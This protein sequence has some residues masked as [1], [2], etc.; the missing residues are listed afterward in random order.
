MDIDEFETL[1]NK[2]N[3]ATDENQNV[4]F[5]PIN[6]KDNQ[7]ISQILKNNQIEKISLAD[8]NS[9]AQKNF[10][11]YKARQKQKQQKVK[12]FSNMTPQQ[13]AALPT[14][15]KVDYLEALFSSNQTA[16]EII[17]FCGK[18]KQNIKACLFN[19]TFPQS[20][21]DNERKSVDRFISLIANRPEI[22][23]KIKNWQNT[24]LEDKKLVI[25]QAAQVFKHVYG[26]KPDIAF[27][28][29]EEEKASNIAN[30]LDENVHINAA[31]YTK[32]KISFNE[33]R[34]QN[35]DNFFAISV[36]LHE[37]THMRQHFTSFNDKLVDRIFSC[38]INNTVVYENKINNKDAIEYKDLYTLQPSEIHAYRLQQYA[39]QQL[40]AKTGIE[41]T[42]LNNLD[43]ETKQIHNK[44]FS[45]A[46]ISKYHSSQK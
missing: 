33:E 25:Q 18:N 3:L 26:L 36:L 1:I 8:F 21:W 12:A 39:E 31:Y 40:T 22:T 15:Q 24:T 43:K 9:L 34:L 37:G 5:T 17:E 16:T 28:T 10:P 4:I 2:C 41:K 11:L 7:L 38:H 42:N 19:L 46:S 20:F 44:A 14:E 13:V 23:D 6:P 32:G 27:F 30:G 45:M 35:S 29:P